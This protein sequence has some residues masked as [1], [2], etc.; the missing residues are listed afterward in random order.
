MN[1]LYTPAVSHRFIASFLFNNIPSPLDIA[2]QRISGL[3]RELQTTQH[4]QGG[5]NARNTWLAEK[6]QHGSLMLE[7]GVMTVTPLTLVFDRVLRGEKAVYADVVIM[8]LNE[9]SLPVASWTLSNALPV[10]WS[11][12][13]F[14]ANSNTVLVNSLELRYQDMRWLG[15]KV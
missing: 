7:R 15:V 4:S 6:I 9:N 1:N 13:D 10:R 11:T 8:L 2:F 3:S 14:D 5:E 12:G